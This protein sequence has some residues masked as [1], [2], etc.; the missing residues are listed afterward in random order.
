M[1]LIRQKRDLMSHDPF[2]HLAPIGRRTFIAGAAAGVLAACGSSGSELPDGSD[3]SGVDSAL[4]EADSWAVIQRYPANSLVPGK[5]R[6]PFSLNRNAEFVIDGPDE[7][8][9]QIVDIDGAPIGGRITAVRRDVTPSP[10]YAFEPVIDAPGVYGIV[11]DGGPESGA[12][13]QVVE[14]DQVAAPLPGDPLPGFD[15]PTISDAG[16]VD[17][18]C[19]REPSC[20]FHEMTLTDALAT[21]QPVAYIIGTPA[22]CPTGSCTPALESLVAAQSDYPGVVFVHAEVYTDLTGTEIAAAVQDLSLAF[23]PVLFLVG[24]DGNVVSRLDAIWD[25]TEVRE[26]LDALTA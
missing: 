9:A 12:N 20:D 24:A 26:H 7:L 22:L 19:T 25:D 11:I 8:G 2:S 3:A 4:L 15:T 18:I 17:P 5:V 6:L 1:S 10:Y 23:E 13:F 21:G 14:R 16:G